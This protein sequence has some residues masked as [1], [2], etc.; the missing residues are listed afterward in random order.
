MAARAAWQRYFTDTDVFV[1]PANFT[2]A[3]P[4]ATVVRLDKKRV[5]LT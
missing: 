2:A 5:A 1:C 3:F 4:H